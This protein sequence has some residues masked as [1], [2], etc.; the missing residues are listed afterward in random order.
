MRACRCVKTRSERRGVVFL[1][2]FFFPSQ[3]IQL[4]KTSKLQAFGPSDYSPG[5]Q[6]KKQTKSQRKDGLRTNVP[7]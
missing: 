4:G 2:F 6:M 1:S 3:Q 7:S 5:L